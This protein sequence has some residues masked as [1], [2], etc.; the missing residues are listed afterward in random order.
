MTKWGPS[1][2]DEGGAGNLRQKY[3]EYKGSARVIEN[4]GNSAAGSTE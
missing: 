2:K 3:R 1:V 4:N